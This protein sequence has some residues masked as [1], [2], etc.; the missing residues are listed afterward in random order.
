MNCDIDKGE[1]CYWDSYG[2]KPNQEVVILMNKLKEQGKKLNINFEIKINKIR[3]QYKNSECGM[4]CI[5]FITSL[6][7]GKTFENIVQTIID[8]DT[9]NH[10]RDVFFNKL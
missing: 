3:H 8:D 4:Y 2:I 5:Y 10:K 9:M 1:I 6:L 7:D